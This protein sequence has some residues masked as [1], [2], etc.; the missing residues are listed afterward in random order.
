MIYL[1]HND[2]FISYDCKGASIAIEANDE[3]RVSFS[4]SYL[5]E[6]DPVP[7]GPEWLGGRICLF[8]YDKGIEVYDLNAKASQ[9]LKVRAVQTVHFFNKNLCLLLK[10]TKAIVFDLTGFKIVSE[11]NL[12]DGWSL[13]RTASGAVI[14]KRKSI[15]FLPNEA[16][17]HPYEF[18]IKLSRTVRAFCFGN[19][20]NVLGYVET[21]IS[22]E[23]F[24]EV[25]L[26]LENGKTEITVLPNT[27][28]FKMPEP[29]WLNWLNFRDKK[30]EALR[31]KNRDL[32]YV[33]ID[34]KESIGLFLYFAKK[35]DP[36]TAIHYTNFGSFQSE[37]TDKTIV[38]EFVELAKCL[39]CPTSYDEFNSIRNDLSQKTKVL[40][41]HLINYLNR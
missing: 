41:Q 35:Y 19:L 22:T 39:S 5:K 10:Q 29:I 30:E 16:P 23:E 1:D 14:C 15:V 24:V 33:K 7:I 2:N 32:H 8:N 37:C 9:F 13:E 28:F 4:L 21:G 20:V 6:A 27:D 36:I 18:K 12:P 25:V 26:D 31:T 40:S 17:F 11:A 38:N 3:K 34:G